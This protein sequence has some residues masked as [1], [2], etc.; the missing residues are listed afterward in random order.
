M[1]SYRL[2]CR[3]GS[4]LSPRVTWNHFL[5]VP[6]VLRP[7][8]RR[9]P[10]PPRPPTDEILP[11]CLA[12]PPVRAEPALQVRPPVRP[13]VL[14]VPRTQVHPQ[15]LGTFRPPD[16]SDPDRPRQESLLALPAAERVETKEGKREL[17][18]TSRPSV[19][20]IRPI[21]LRAPDSRQVSHSFLYLSPRTATNI[22]DHDCCQR[23]SRSRA[24]DRK[25]A[26]GATGGRVWVCRL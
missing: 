8:A 21:A 2:A 26:E 3:R 25:V 18:E 14:R 9:V 15:T 4:G 6:T 23:V 1:P 22:L 20:Q 17:P 5:F 12:T 19:P 24:H 11:A 7:R 10:L 16:R 13:V